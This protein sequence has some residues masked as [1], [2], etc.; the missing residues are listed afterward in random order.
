LD[1]RAVPIAS[2]V[3]DRALS[4]PKGFW[5]EEQFWAHWHDANRKAEDDI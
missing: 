5:A 1:F 4:M 2:V 3:R